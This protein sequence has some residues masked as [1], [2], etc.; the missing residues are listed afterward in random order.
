MGRYVK[1]G[2]VYIE[3]ASNI[4]RVEFQG[5]IYRRY[6]DSPHPH[7]R[8]YFTRSR[9]FLHRAVWEFHNGPIPVGHHVHHK[10]ENFLNNA[11]GNLEC[12]PASVHANKKHKKRTEY[13]RSKEQHAHLARIR[14]AAAQWHSSPEGRAWHSE[15]GRRTWIERKKH[16]LI[17]A[18]CGAPFSA[19]IARA[20][21]CGK[22]CQNRNWYKRH[23]DYG[24]Q[25]RAK[26]KAQ[27][28]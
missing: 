12:L 17:C 24:A 13:A 6:P 27:R 5:K 21:F 10:D 4:D 8:R 16:E 25:K 9:E 7:L 23:P 28:I 1:K 19:F 14:K 20:K 2:R 22:S 15:N 3:T 11:I 26:Q 18:E